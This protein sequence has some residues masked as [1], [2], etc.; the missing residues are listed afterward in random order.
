[1]PWLA[2]RPIRD[3]ARFEP[4]VTNAFSVSSSARSTVELV[5]RERGFRARFGDEHVRVRAALEAGPRQHGRDAP[6]AARAFAELIGVAGDEAEEAGERQ[7]REEIG[8]RDA[9][10]RRRGRKLAFGRADVG[11]ALQQRRRRV[12]G[13]RRQ[14]RRDLAE[15]ELG[16]QRAG[17]LAEQHREPVRRNDLGRDERRNRRLGRGPPRLGAS[18]V[19]LAAAAELEPYARELERL[20]LIDLSS[21]A[22][23]RGAS[24]RRAAPRSC[25]RP[26]PRRAPARRANRRRRRRLS[27]P[28]AWTPRRTRP[29]RSSSHSVARPAS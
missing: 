10:A 13:D 19:E 4:Y 1:M 21:C 6:G 29:K 24:A 23:R 7:A 28:A 26:R 16:H 27:A 2:R 5:R 17:P 15:G 25:A 8:F 20:L 18:D 3:A 12:D 11:P 14:V 22:R 9:D